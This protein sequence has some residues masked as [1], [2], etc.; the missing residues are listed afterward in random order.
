[1]PKVGVFSF[2]VGVFAYLD[3]RCSMLDVHFFHPALAGLFGH[4]KKFLVFFAQNSIGN[5]L[6]EKSRQFTCICYRRLAR[7]LLAYIDRG[8]LIYGTHLFYKG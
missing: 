3:V 5:C 4:C 2:D 7:V 8:L 6:I 1:M